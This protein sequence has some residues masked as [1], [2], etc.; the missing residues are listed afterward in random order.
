MMLRYYLMHPDTDV[1]QTAQPQ[2]SYSVDFIVY[3]RAKYLVVQLDP[4]FY[5]GG[6]IILFSCLLI[7]LLHSQQLLLLVEVEVGG[8]AL[9]HL[10]THAF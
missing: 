6:K 5:G 8:D 4:T 7:L 1:C 2:M 9:V 3:S 10:N